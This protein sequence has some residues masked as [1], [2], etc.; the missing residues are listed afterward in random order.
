MSSFANTLA[1]SCRDLMPKSVE[2]QIT[3][4]KTP[5]Y[6]VTKEVPGRIYTMSKDTKLIVVVR[7][8]VTR[9]ISDYTQTRSKKPDIPSF[10]SLTFKNSTT[11]LI[12]ST[13]SA[14]QIGMYAR[15]LERWLKFFPINQILFV[16]GERLISDPAAE[17]LL[18]GNDP[19]FSVSLDHMPDTTH[20]VCPLLPHIVVVTNPQTLILPHHVNCEPGTV[21]KLTLT[22]QMFLQREICNER[23][24]DLKT[25]AYEMVFFTQYLWYMK[26]I[27]VTQTEDPS[28]RKA[29]KYQHWPPV[30]AVSEL[31]VILEQ[32]ATAA[33]LSM[34]VTKRQN[35]SSQ[36]RYFPRLEKLLDTLMLSLLILL[37]DG[38]EE[39]AI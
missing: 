17:D 2:G 9:A 35:K 27:Y 34:T 12:D 25:Y 20:K 4:E 24:T 29:L 1:L 10:E 31:M 16:S 21:E 13:W 14:L 11:G 37:H 26:D 30:R 18:D 23:E 33:A 3:M 15:H 22:L 19:T 8:P 7:D 6:F 36:W 5:S 38:R 32:A 28:L 39:K